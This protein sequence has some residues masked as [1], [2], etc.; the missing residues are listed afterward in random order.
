IEPAIR[1]AVGNARIVIVSVV[2]ALV[3]VGVALTTLGREIIPTLDAVSYTNLRTHQTPVNL[4]RRL[5]VIKKNNKKASK[6]W[7]HENI[8]LGGFQY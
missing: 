6:I 3:V 1:A 5:L 7:R 4:V 8:R 2:A